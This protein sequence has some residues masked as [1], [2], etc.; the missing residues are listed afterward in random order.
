MRKPPP[1]TS[2]IKPLMQSH[3]PF[4]SRIFTVAKYC[5]GTVVLAQHH[6]LLCDEPGTSRLCH[7]CQK[8]L[9]NARHSCQQCALP[10]EHF[11]LFCGQCLKQAPAFD[12]VFSPFLYQAPISTLI[13]DY[14]QKSHDYTGK[15]LSD[16]F[17]QSV[18][19]HYRQEHLPQPTFITHVPL[20]WRNQWRRGFN[21][22]ANFSHALSRHMNIA[23]FSHSRRV[24]W[25]MSQKTLSKKERTQSLRGSFLITKPLNGESVVI[26]D[27]VMTT[28]ATVNT[29]ATELKKAGAGRVSVWVLA[30]TPNYRFK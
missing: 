13:L 16:L 14:K 4:Y 23:H 26:V 9:L 18:S 19:R 25:T 10:L 28:G 30:R 8:L 24:K 15:A 7:Y 21:Q 17:C 20:H 27:D 12:Y 3:K 5:I 2:C 11:A 29:L 6:C 1:K 22:S